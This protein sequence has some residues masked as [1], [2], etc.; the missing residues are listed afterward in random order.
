MK[1][2]SLA[3]ALLTM[4]VLFASIFAPSSAAA[5]PSSD[6]VQPDI[7]GGTP[8]AN[9]T[10]MASLQTL[11]GSHTC[12]AS[13][14]HANWA[15][16]ARHCV[17]GVSPS[18]RQLRVGSSNRTSGGVVVPVSAIF[19]HAT[20]DL[21]LLQIGTVPAGYT[22][23]LIA[24]TSG[25]VGTFTRIMGWGQTCPNPGGCGAPVQLQQLNTSIVNDALCSGIVAA[26]E[27]CTN[28][29]GGV[30]GACYGDSGGPEIK[31]VG[32][33]WQLIG[34]TSRSGGGSVCAVA[35]SI[36]VDVPAFRPWI[37]A[38]TGLPL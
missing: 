19:N 21:S 18:T 27:I 6:G 36:Y 37:Q 12:G 35:P 8:A 25:P 30:A 2:R 26:T 31:S 17:A 22:P 32:G 15:V 29:P 3:G 16:T 33:R 24:A 20:G 5:P 14:V 11:T 38:T 1:L 4:A 28:N 9:Y 10:F 34:A 7:V 13:V 23:I